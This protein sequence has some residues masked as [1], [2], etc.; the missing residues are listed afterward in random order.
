MASPGRDDYHSTLLSIAELVARLVAQLRRNNET[1]AE[2]KG[3]REPTSGDCASTGKCC[4]YNNGAPIELG[5]KEYKLLL[6][7][8]KTRRGFLRKGSSIRRCGTRSFI[9]T[10]TP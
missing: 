9:L 3:R 2:G 8:M 1:D 7:F 4:A 6:Y 5:A 10:T